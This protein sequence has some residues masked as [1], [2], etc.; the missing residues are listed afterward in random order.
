VGNANARYK[1]GYT[2]SIFD[3]SVIQRLLE[4][5]IERGIAMEN[6]PGTRPVDIKKEMSAA[7]EKGG[8]EL[9]TADS[10]EELAKKIGVDPSVLRATVNEYNG[11]CEKRHDDLFAKDQTSAP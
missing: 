11:F 4:R 6:P 8:E 9:F 7:L 10:I 2:Y 3:D 5:G 1:E